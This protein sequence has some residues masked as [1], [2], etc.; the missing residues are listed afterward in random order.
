[1]GVL[2][3]YSRVLIDPD[4]KFERISKNSIYRVNKLLNL[5]NGNC[6]L[7]HNPLLFLSLSVYSKNARKREKIVNDLTVASCMRLECR[8]ITSL[9]RGKRKNLLVLLTFNVYTLLS[10]QKNSRRNFPFR[11]NAFVCKRVC[12]VG[13]KRK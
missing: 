5:Q 13:E 7:S 10:F 12:G 4:G 3:K 11:L 2:C 8:F 9:C 6:T 1:M